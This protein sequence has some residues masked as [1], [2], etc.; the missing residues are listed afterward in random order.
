MERQHRIPMLRLNRSWKDEGKGATVAERGGRCRHA[1]LWVSEVESSGRVSC[2][3]RPRECSSARPCEI[4]RHPHGSLA[5]CRAAV[6]LHDAISHERAVAHDTQG[7]S[8]DGAGGRRVSR[9]L[10]AS[11]PGPSREPGCE[12]RCSSALFLRHFAPRFAGGLRVTA[13]EDSPAAPRRRIAAPWAHPTSDL[14]APTTAQRHRP[15]EAAAGLVPCP[16]GGVRR[17]R[18]RARARRGAGSRTASGAP[19]RRARRA[20][21]PCAAGDRTDQRSRHLDRRRRR[22]AR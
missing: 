18:W 15:R 2:G 19:A 1:A 13:T 3:S 17:G 21:R 4:A 22:A 7:C 5:A 8:G 10:R 20:G 9:R 12:R 14:C 6:H 11:A 16:T